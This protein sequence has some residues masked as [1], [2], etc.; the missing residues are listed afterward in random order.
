MNVTRRTLLAALALAP[1]P[2]LAQG[3]PPEAGVDYAELRPPQAVESPGKVEVTE[4]FWYGCPHCYNL[5][6]LLEKW[7]RGLPKD[8]AFRRV[9]AVFND[10]WA[11]D[12][13][14]FYSFEALGVLDRVH[15]PFFDAIHKDRLNPGEVSARDAWL[16]KQGV[17][18]KRFEDAFR[19]FGVQAKVR[20]ARKA[21]IDYRIDGTPAMA[22]QGRYTISA[23]QARTHANMLAI[24]SYLIGVARKAG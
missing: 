3:R 21:S 13:A 24:A 9:P 20:Q 22:V 17:D 15:G 7:V 8:V 16:K 19:S 4:F 6:P 18:P 14:I 2:A 5:E 1:L 10:T 23:E 11:R 12:A